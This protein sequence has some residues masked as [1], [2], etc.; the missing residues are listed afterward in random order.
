VVSEYLTIS[1]IEKQTGISNSTCR[2]YLTTFERFFVVKG[3]SRLKKY[4]SSSVGILI[5]IRDLY[6]DGRDTDEI[7][8]ILINEFPMVIDGDEQQEVGNQTPT[9]ATSDDLIL[10]KQQL[11]EQ[12]QFNIKLIEKMERQ[13]L[14]NQALLQKLDEQKLYIERSIENRDRLLMETLKENQQARIEQAAAQQKKGFFSK[15]F[16]KD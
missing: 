8:N 5:R 11:D 12:T 16:K 2:R 14:F 1:E 4:E 6:N 9:L 10:I 7:H 15:L 13:E 3:G